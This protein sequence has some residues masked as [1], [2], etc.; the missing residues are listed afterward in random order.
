MYDI[1]QSGLHYEAKMKKPKDVE[2][3]SARLAEAAAAPLVP[4]PVK[5]QVVTVSEPQQR[6]KAPNRR[7]KSLF[8]RLP[9]E[10]FEKYDAQAVERT[11]ATGRGVTVQ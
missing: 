5:Q 8:L 10:L 11:K 1:G 3:L 9:E 6:R 4:Q 7:S 2:D